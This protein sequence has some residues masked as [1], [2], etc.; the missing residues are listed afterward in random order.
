M[1]IVIAIFLGIL[2]GGVVNGGLV[3][4]GA[5]IIPPP[6]GVDPSDVESIKENI[7]RYEPKHFI[8]PLLAHALGTL[9]GA[10]V[11][12]GLSPTNQ[13]RSA[14]IIGFFFLLGGVGMAFLVPGPAWFVATDLVVC[15]LPMAWIG[16]RVFLKKA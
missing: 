16:G 9:V 15:Y 10:A 4:G 12:A 6:E 14:R 13:M 11:A 5:A 7:D 2:V 3:A 8:P 1:K